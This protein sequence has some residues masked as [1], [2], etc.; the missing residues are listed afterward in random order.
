MVRL[1]HGAYGYEDEAVCAIFPE[2]AASN[3]RL[4]IDGWFPINGLN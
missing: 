1:H 2:R 3:L 4:F